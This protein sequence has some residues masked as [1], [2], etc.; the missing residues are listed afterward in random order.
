MYLIDDKYKIKKLKKLLIDSVNN[1]LNKWTKSSVIK[2][3]NLIISYYSPAYNNSTK[4]ALEINNDSKYFYFIT[5]KTS[6]Y[7]YEIIHDF[8]YNMYS[9]SMKKILKKIR[10]NI[11]EDNVI[12]T[13]K[14]I[15][16]KSTAELRKEKLNK[17]NE[18]N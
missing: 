16:A 1:D 7:N 17:I 9:R 14:N 6:G 5:K 11:F 3:N 10:N 15:N 13:D 4:F 8:F 18:K 12:Q 2:D